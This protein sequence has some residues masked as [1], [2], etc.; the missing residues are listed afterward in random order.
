MG[1]FRGVQRPGRKVSVR[2]LVARRNYAVAG[3][4]S[5]FGVDDDYSDAGSYDPEP[6]ADPYDESA[7]LDMSPVTDPVAAAGVPDLGGGLSLASL[8]SAGGAL[9]PFLGGGL[10]SLKDFF[11]SSGGSAAAAGMGALANPKTRAAAKRALKYGIG[12]LL[13]RAP[14]SGRRMNPGNFRA[15]HRALRRLS[16]FE[17]A[18]KRVYKFTHPRPGRSG[19]KF[20]RRRRRK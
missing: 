17:H 18:A 10:S 3:D 13:G 14:R 6:A 7:G 1:G 2:S 15:L 20:R 8:G 9:A 11:G 19:F 4:L 5:D 12:K 16:S